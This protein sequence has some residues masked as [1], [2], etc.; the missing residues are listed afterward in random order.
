[1]A[2]LDYAKV[3][4]RFALTVGD[5]ADVDEDPDTIWC[6]QGT[7]L[8][9]PLQTF[10]KVAGA[11][12]PF[13]AGHSVIECT[14]DT[15]GYLTYAGRR[16]VNVVDLT[17]DKVNPKIA[18]GKA[19]H[20]VTFKNV[21]ASG[22]AVNFSDVY[23]RVTK[24]GANGDGENDLT[25]ISPVVPGTAQAI[26]RGETGSSV[27]AMAIEGGDL[28]STLSDGTELNAGPVPTGPGGSDAGVASYLDDEESATTSSL[29]ARMA[30]LT[31]LEG[32][33]FRAR[34][35]A[36]I[37]EQVDVETAARQTAVSGLQDQIDNWS[38]FGT[39][40]GDWTATTYDA[41]DIVAHSGSTW[42]ATTAAAASDEPGVAA[43]WQELPATVDASA[44]SDIADLETR[45]PANLPVPGVLVRWV[46]EDGVQVWPGD[47]LEEDGGPSDVS[48]AMMRSR[49]DGFYEP[50]GGSAAT[51][52]QLVLDGDSMTQGGHG[53]VAPL[54]W[55]E[56]IDP[57]TDLDVVNLG[58]SGS[59]AAEIGMRASS[60]VP[61]VT[62]PDGTIPADTTP[63]AVTWTPPDG[64]RLSGTSTTDFTTT[65]TI[66]GVAATLTFDRSEQTWSLARTSAGTAI[67]VA[68]PIAFVPDDSYP[69]E[70]HVLWAGRNDIPTG[71]AAAAFTSIRKTIDR[72]RDQGSAF[73]VVS[74]TN[75]TGEASGTANYDTLIELNTLIQEYA[76]REY[77]D[78][79][80]RMIREG[81]ALA[82]VSE[83]A[84]DTTAISEDRI[85]DS[86]M[87]DN[88]HFNENGRT[89]A[90]AIILDELQIRSLV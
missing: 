40:M 41:G 31:D 39:L 11:A 68:S 76:P 52:T 79:R 23:V 33:A 72:Y 47:A 53:G 9:Q 43:L 46:T 30:A 82:G 71:T 83:T 18:S 88:T 34:Q 32:S 61:L 24:D 78:L 74:V 59:T 48:V 8:I 29:D 70:V 54:T 36:S 80:G 51:Y 22:T 64:G 12:T 77:A 50:L 62:I 56:V 5:G 15:E 1:M 6:D 57:Q 19:T 49:L 69:A 85:P 28:V 45:A 7:V 84:A 26:Y 16:Y 35:S 67:E 63:V 44:R 14:I 38:T 10:T 20:L 81:L 13:T 25:I 66:R 4:G 3:T 42:G 87:Y 60:V 27:A 75:K 58:R 21:K 90:A 2:D 65:G 55:G 17:S 73:I 89:A 86:L 37:G